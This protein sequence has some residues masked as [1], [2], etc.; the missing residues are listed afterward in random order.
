MNGSA[1]HIAGDVERHSNSGHGCDDAFDL[2][3]Q[4]LIGGDGDSHGWW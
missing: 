1:E 3:A 2:E 4:G